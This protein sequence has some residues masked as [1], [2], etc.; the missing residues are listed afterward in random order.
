MG[1]RIVFMGTPQFASG[2]LRALLDAGMEIAAV[3]TMPDKPI[4]R[5]RKI[6]ISDVK[7]TASEAGIPILQPSNLKDSA[8]IEQL[9]SYRADLQ[10]VVAFRML[11]QSV[12]GM[13]PLGTFNLHA[14][15]LPKYRGAAPIQ[16][17]IWNGESESGVT[18]FLLDKDLDTGAILYQE[19]IE[20]APD[21]TAGS[22]HDKLLAIGAP[23]VVRTA[24]DL[25]DG[26]IQARTQ[27]WNREEDLPYAPKIFKE[28]CYLDFNRPAQELHRQVRALSPHPGAIAVLNNPEKG[29]SLPIKILESDFLQ[30]NAKSYEQGRF[31]TDGKSHLYI[32]CG[33]GNILSVKKMQ[34]P[35]KKPL[36]TEDCLRGFRLDS[37][38]KQFFQKV[39]NQ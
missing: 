33:D 9:R 5:G 20:I 36:T 6:G 13:P 37:C 4:G 27:T 39:I 35:G 38:E 22:L 15:L 14:S 28:D 21:E 29:I 16:R 26:K 30:K 24:Q 23:L 17:A 7:R 8:F 12:W 34:L 18:T 31:Q 11:P 3:V 19:R 25:F 1:R 32:F 10:I 2:C